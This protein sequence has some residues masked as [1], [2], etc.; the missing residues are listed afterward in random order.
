M[1]ATERIKYLMD[2][3]GWSAYRLSKN[4]GLSENTIA[5]IL[6]R[7]SLPSVSTLEAICKGFGITMS[8]FFAEGEL[9]EVSPDTKQLIE[10]WAG[11]SIEQKASV[12]EL[13]KN[14][15]QK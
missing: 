5:T 4:S 6:K 2:Q 7:N 10:Y 8:E 9:I 14:M 3:R 11:L 13:V 1:D 15:N 12:L